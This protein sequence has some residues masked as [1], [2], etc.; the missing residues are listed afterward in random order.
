MAILTVLAADMA[1]RMGAWEPLAK[2]ESNAGQ[3]I[4]LKHALLAPDLER[5]DVVTIGD[6]RAMYGID[7]AKLYAHGK[8]HGWNHYN[9]SIPGMHWLGL[10]AVHRWT[11]EQVNNPSAVVITATIDSFNNIGN[12]AYELSLVTPLVGMF[13]DPSMSIAV[14]PDQKLLAT[15]GR[16]SPLIA[17][18]ED[19][20]DI[21]SQPMSRVR[22]LAWR[23]RHPVTATYL[24]QSHRKDENIC[25][26]DINSL[27][28]CAATRTQDHPATVSQCRTK[29]AAPKRPDYRPGNSVNRPAHLPQVLA[30]RQRELRQLARSQNVIVV[31]MPILKLWQQEISPIGAEEWAYEVLDPLVKEGTIDLIDFTHLFDNDKDNGCSSFFDLYHQNAKGQDRLTSQLLPRLEEILKA[32][33]ASAQNVGLLSVE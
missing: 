9:L 32:R 2:F 12:G 1:F 31:L 26:I 22:E 18:R 6:S 3:V 28:Q 33:R 16:Y 5:L 23:M 14:P 30:L 19:I 24:R 10:N 27:S 7:H 8:S 11:A 29:L 13:G 21:A 15:F 20:Q 4:A 25:A 17:Y